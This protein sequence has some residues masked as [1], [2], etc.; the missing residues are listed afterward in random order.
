[1]IIGRRI[2]R[3]LKIIERERKFEK[4]CANIL[5]CDA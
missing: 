3:I 5:N 2:D 4:W 1:M